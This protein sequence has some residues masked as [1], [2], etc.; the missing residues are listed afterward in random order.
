[1]KYCPDWEYNQKTPKDANIQVGK[2]KE[3]ESKG[4]VSARLKKPLSGV[5]PS[6]P[7]KYH[8]GM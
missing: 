3:A 1:M 4:T 7:K 8:P 5:Q 6:V 2:N